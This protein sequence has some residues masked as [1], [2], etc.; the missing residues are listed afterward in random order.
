[1]EDVKAPSFPSRDRLAALLPGFRLDPEP[2]S[3]TNMS[4]I[5]RATETRLH[6]REVVVKVMAEELADDARFR[7]RFLREVQVMATLRHPNILEVITASTSDAPLLYL[8]TPRADTDLRTLL[9]S[10]PPLDLATAVRIIRQLAAALDYAHDMGVIHRDVKPGNVLLLGKDAHVYLCDF[11]AAKESH[12]EQLTTSGLAPGTPGYSAP[13]Q[14]YST[15]YGDE[16]AD[17]VPIGQRP[18]APPPDR[19]IDVYSLGAV[20]HYSLTG[21][22]PFDHTELRAVIGAQL[23]GEQ[24]RVSELR[25]D[26]P[27]A[28]DRVVLKAM[29]LDPDERYRTCAE[30]VDALADVTGPV[31]AGPPPARRP[32][33]RSRPVLAAAVAVAVLAAVAVAVVRFGPGWGGSPT[34]ELLARIPASLREDC[35]P[36]DGAGG[37]PGASDVV[38]CVADGREVTFSLFDHI[39]TMDSAYAGAVEQARVAR[40]TGD[41][42]VA[43]GAE[44]RYPGYGEPTGR[45]LCYSLG[46]TSS[47]VWTNDAARTVGQVDSRDTGDIGLEQAWATWVGLPPYP[48]DAEQALA[49]LVELQSCHRP[50]ASSLDAFRNLLAAVECASPGDGANRVSYYQFADLDGLR[51]TYNQQVNEVGAPF[52]DSCEADTPGFLGDRGLELRGAEVGRF[53]CYRGPQDEPVI[54]WTFDAMFVMG[55]A[56]GTEPEA[57]LDWWRFDYYGW[58]T[59]NAAISQAVNAAADPPFPNPRERALLQHIPPPSR[60]DCMRPSQQQIERNLTRNPVAAVGCGPTRGV[61]YVFY[62][63]MDS[64]AAMNADFESFNAGTTGPPCTTAP[65]DFEGNAPYSRGGA[66]GQLA[67]FSRDDGSTVMIWTDTRRNI[68]T[69]AFEGF[70]P[71]TILD[72]WHTEAGPL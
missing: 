64:P 25:P 56:A 34:E 38:T 59:P 61:S 45:V 43:T 14:L 62:Y 19:A 58:E 70:E 51:R 41:C 27:K 42:T 30:L 8:V 3:R 71:A 49:D 1:V 69:F 68:M 57:L 22:P 33:W 31:V 24:P 72:W 9:K 65:P 11:G 13:E 4:A 2:M 40:A 20:L 32:R 52:V 28:L 12:G 63:Q 37:R 15:A 60:V 6:H 66:S 36:A 18:P 54:T 67:C 39:S 26:L 10:R 7:S 48:T 5:Y 50:P 47:V 23:R 46:A 29:A 53:L 55:R 16:A 35:R 21:R 44:H 17:T